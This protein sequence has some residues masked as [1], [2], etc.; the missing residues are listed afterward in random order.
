MST[1]TENNVDMASVTEHLQRL[2]S[3][4]ERLDAEIE[5]LCPCLGLGHIMTLYF[6]W[7]LLTNALVLLNLAAKIF[8]VFGGD[9]DYIQR[10]LVDPELSLVKQCDILDFPPE[11]SLEE[12]LMPTLQQLEFCVVQMAYE[13]AELENLVLGVDGDTTFLLDWVHQRATLCH[14]VAT[15]IVLP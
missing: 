7:D 8:V 4:A 10:L 13:V 9:Y 6:T 11:M 1:A 14:T 15:N 12:L 2:V 3:F 5:T